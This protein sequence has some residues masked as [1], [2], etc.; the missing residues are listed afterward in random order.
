MS[1]LSSSVLDENDLAELVTWRHHLHRMPDLSGE[2]VATAAEVTRFMAETSPDEIVAGL[3]GTGVAVIYRGRLPGP[4]VMFRAELD[5]LP[6]EERGTTEHRSTVAGKGHMCGHDG[7]MTILAALGRTFGRQRPACGRAILLFQPAEETGAGA[8]AVLA[9]P[10]FLALKPDY[11]LSLHNMPG[12][13]LGHAWLKDGPANCASRGMRIT[14]SGRTAHAASPETGLSPVRA[15]STLLQALTALGS[16]TLEDGDLRR[17][18]IT[19]ATVGEPAF[20]IAPG[21]AEIWATLRSS[22]DDAMAALVEQAE[23]L[24]RNA[25]E[26]DGLGVGIDYSDIFGHCLNDPEAAAILRRAMDAENIPHQA[27][28]P[29]RASEDFGRFA[30]VSKSAMLFLGAGEA[31]P[32]LHD[33]RYDFPD[34]LIETGARIFLAAA[35]ELLGAPHR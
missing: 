8:E 9:D 35:R 22:T 2:E 28:Q 11:S 30:T 24:V 21:E 6:I 13:P 12:L 1:A 18:T 4:T 3:G 15:V 17:V 14:L 25:A 5:G 32:A 23:T 33:P 29:L 10:R 31:H 19:H 27:G 7:H 20:G 16:G 26:Q 34:P